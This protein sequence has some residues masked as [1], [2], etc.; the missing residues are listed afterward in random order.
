MD[1]QQLL[2]AGLL[3]PAALTDHIINEIPAVSTRIADMGLFASEGM[4]T[5]MMR[6]EFDGQ[7]LTLVPTAPRGAPA[8]PKALGTTRERYFKAVHLPQRSTV[9][10]DE[11]LYIRARTGTDFEK[12]VGGVRGKINALQVV[13]KRDLDYTIEYHRFGAL[14]GLIKDAD[15][16]TI[17]DLYDE[18]D[19]TQQEQ[20]MVLGTAGTKVR[21]KVLELKRKIESALGAIGYTRIHVFASPEFMD[22]LVS[23]ADV[24]RAYERFQDGAALRDDP[25]KGFVFGATGVT[26]EEVGESVR[27][28]RLVPAGEAIA[29]PVGVPGMFVTGYA[30]AD[31]MDA[32]GAETPVL[33]LPYYSKPYPLQYDKGLELYSQSNPLNLNLRPLAVIR[34]TTN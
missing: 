16:S 5:E 4:M 23:H 28:E 12:F 3:Q 30:P 15:G 26:F 24:E 25:R 19:V 2:N 8:Q 10:A 31:T 20:A 1:L 21:I 7:S 17:I 6:V 11:L 18:F 32:I 27:G 33:G 14:K 9:L 34:L 13:Q 22:K 29:F